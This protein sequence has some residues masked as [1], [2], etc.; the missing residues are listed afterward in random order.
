MKVFKLNVYLTL[1]SSVMELK[2]LST[3][4]KIIWG[5]INPNIDIL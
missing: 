1:S 5:E 4:K 2:I 3:R